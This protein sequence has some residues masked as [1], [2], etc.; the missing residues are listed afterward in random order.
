MSDTL[1]I[2]IDA[3]T[4]I[5]YTRLLTK[6]F[7]NGLPTQFPASLFQQYIDKEFDIRIFYLNGT[8]YPMVI[9]SQKDRKT[10]IDFRNYNFIDPNRTIPFKLPKEIE[11]KLTHFMREKKMDASSIDMVK[12]K[13]TGKYYFLEVNPWGQFGMVSKPCNYFLEKKIAE[14][15]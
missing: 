11:N 8:L 5:T 1:I 2:E 14:L 6:K 9:F 10:K 12:C 15:L 13:L 7:I 3:Q 4:K